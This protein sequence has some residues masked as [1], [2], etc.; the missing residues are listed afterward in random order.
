MKILSCNLRGYGEEDGENAWLY[1]KDLCI[2]TIKSEDADIICFQEMMQI[3]DMKSAFPD[4]D[5]YGM[6]H[7]P[8]ER[9]PRNC[10]FFRRKNY[11]LISCSGYWLSETPHIPGSK[12]WDSRC[13]RLANWVRLE[14]RARGV[15][16]RVVN[17][18]LDHVSQQA[19]EKQAALIV[20]DA[21][22][23]PDDYP[24][25]LT[26]DMNCDTS[27]RTIDIFKAGG[28][29]DSYGAVHPTENPGHTFHAFKGTE[30]DGS[31]GKMDWI[32][33]KGAFSVTGAE[34][35]TG[36]LDGRFPSDHYFVSADVSVKL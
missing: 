31:T 29:L 15:E 7:E 1:R 30:Y 6:A 26:G 22:V 28:W 8:G 33:F 24:Q 13:I 5:M 18:H 32:F 9:Y 2:N 10:I 17:T 19:R 35:I 12:S 23:Y 34:V 14:D 16:C 21:A 25:I 11:N 3:S 36:A 27:N 4:Y 20:E